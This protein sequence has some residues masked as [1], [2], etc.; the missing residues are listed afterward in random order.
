MDATRIEGPALVND[1]APFQEA[2]PAETFIAT[3]PLAGYGE[4]F[5]PSKSQ[6]PIAHIVR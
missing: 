1:V 2:I 3:N 5:D 6:C 4:D